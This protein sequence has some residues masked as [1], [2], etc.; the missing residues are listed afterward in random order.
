VLWV[1]TDG[2]GVHRVNE[3][4]EGSVVSIDNWDASRGLLDNGIM[5]VEGDDDGSLWLSTRHGISRLDPASGRVA[6]Y[7]RVSGLPVINFNTGASSADYRWIYFGSVDGLLSIPRGSEMV[8]RSPSPLHVTKIQ[9]LTEGTEQPMPLAKL[10]GGF[11]TKSGD[12]LAIEF[13]VL[14]YSETPHEYQ[15]RLN[16]GDEWTALGKRRQLTFFGLAAGHYLFEVRGRDAFGNWSTS[17]AVGFE[18]VP[19]FWKTTWFRVLAIAAIVLLALGLHLTRLRSLRLRNAVLEQLQQQR[20]Q[21]FAQAERSQREL[22]EAYAGLR[23]LTDRLESAKE[24]ERS[25]ISRELHDEF[26]QT[27]TAAKLNLQMLRSVTADSAVA[28]RL[29][30]SVTMIDGMIRQARNIALGLRP[31]LLDEAGLVAALDHHLEALAGRSGVRIEFDAANGGARIPPEMNVTVFR[32]VQEAVNNALR[33]AQASNIRVTLSEEANALRLIVEDDGIGF[34]REAVAQRTK[35]GEHLGLLGMTERV[36]S[37][38]GELLLDSRPGSGS[39]IE[40]RIPFVRE[41][42]VS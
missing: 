33:H 25:H 40:V 17:P 36:R 28:Q 37:A 15:Y 6:N 3:D 8:A 11:E 27:L 10:T 39:R 38:G 35:R 30:D 32:L 29:E 4:A 19:P 31:P 24:E 41:E 21:A 7:V 13:S 20:E 26:G 9:S 14:D 16:K 1:A 5:A 34:D 23:Q 42:L 22:E 2:G 18:V 12:G